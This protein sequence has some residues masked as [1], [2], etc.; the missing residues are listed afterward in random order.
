MLRDFSRNNRGKISTL[1]TPCL[2]NFW[3]GFRVLVIYRLDSK[4]GSLQTGVL[5]ALTSIPSNGH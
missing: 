5:S 3:K 1:T 2:S 4:F